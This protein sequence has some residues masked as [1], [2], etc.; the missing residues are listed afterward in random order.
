MLSDFP[1]KAWHFCRALRKYVLV[2]SKEVGKLAFLFGVHTSP[3]LHSFG[4]FFGID[5]HGL[6]ILGC[7]ENTGRQGH[8]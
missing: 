3:D 6:S 7:L 4:R 8:G 2:A 5:L 1:V